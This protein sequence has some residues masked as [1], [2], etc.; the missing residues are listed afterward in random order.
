MSYFNPSIHTHTRKD[1][2]IRISI[3]LSSHPSIQPCILTTINY[4]S[5]HLYIHRAIQLSIS[6]SIYLSI[7]IDK[8]RESERERKRKKERKRQNERKKD[9]QKERK[10]RKKER[11]KQA[12]REKQTKRIYSLQFCFPMNPE[13]GSTMIIH[14]PYSDKSQNLRNDRVLGRVVH[15][16]RSWRAA[17]AR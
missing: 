17:P 12:K 14:D 6:L 16:T 5:F 9:R 11:E 10:K 3:Y 13:I 15:H 1:M 4:P 7:Y 2:D 8:G